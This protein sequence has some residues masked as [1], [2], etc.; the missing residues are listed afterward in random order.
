MPE[1]IPKSRERQ[2]P[3][4]PVVTVYP[5]SGTLRVNESAHV[6]IGRAN[7]VEQAIDDGET[8]KF[9]LRPTSSEGEYHLTDSGSG[10]FVSVVRGFQRLGIDVTDLDETRYYRP[11]LEGDYLVIEVDNFVTDIER[12]NELGDSDG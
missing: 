6:L 9:M 4:K 12:F 1:K 2:G 5:S 11:H 3:S 8:R 7:R 10:A